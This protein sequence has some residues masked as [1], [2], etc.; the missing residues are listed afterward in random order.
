MAG[1]WIKMRADLL[2]SPKV[3]RM[4][5]ALKADRLHVIGGL[6]AVWCLFDAHS[7]D[8]ILD[9]YTPPAL[10][11][12]VGWPGFSA[13]MIAVEWLALDGDSLS[14]P[15]FDEHNSKPAKRRA[16]EAQRKR[17][18]REETSASNADKKRTREEKMSLPKG[19]DVPAT[20]TAKL[21]PK[22]KPSPMPDGF[23]I[24][25]RVRTWATEKGH[26]QLDDY[27]EFFVS[28]VKAKG[29]VYVD[30]DE[31]LMGCIREDWPEYRKVNGKASAGPSGP[32][33][34]SSNEGIDRKA[35]E[36]DM[37]A[38]GNESYSDLKD[39]IF[40]RLRAQS[41]APRRVAA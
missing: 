15:R 9:G 21:S 29:Y 8:G 5:S 24:S 41:G 23:G 7:E 6:L 10:D 18:E 31:A 32:D 38:R 12:M 2:T 36:L 26:G 14:V 40:N 3:V 25:E 1:D 22:A 13:A 16:M 27:L 39:R 4:A 37:Q 17:K 30:W 20:K 33:W 28:K 35:R 19:K 34:W 11:G